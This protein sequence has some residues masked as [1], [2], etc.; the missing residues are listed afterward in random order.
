MQMMRILDW[1]SRRL[2]PYFSRVRPADETLWHKWETP[3]R[4]LLLRG[5]PDTGMGQ[6]WRRRTDKGCEYKVDKETFAD[7]AENQ[8]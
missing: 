7:W 1:I 8:W 6:L 4:P 3:L 5:Q 2:D